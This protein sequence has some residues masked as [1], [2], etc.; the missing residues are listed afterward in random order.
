MATAKKS[1]APAARRKRGQAAPAQGLGA[2]VQVRDLFALLE[3]V[4]TLLG[5]VVGENIEVV[6]HD[7]SAPG[8]SVRAIAN[9][10]VSGRNLGDP[11]LS[12]PREDA[13]FSELYRDVAGTGTISWSIV[14]AYQ[15]TNAAGRQLRSATLLFRDGVGL[16]VAALC[17]NADMTV[18]EMAHGWL[19]QMLHRKPKP[20]RSQ[21]PAAG[22]GLEAMMQEIIDD[23][24]QRFMKPPALMNKEEK[25]YAVEAMMH[26]GLFL[27][28]NSVEQVAA[29]L[30]V[31]R[32]TIYNYIEQIKQ[33]K[34]ASRQ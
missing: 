24:V 8:S 29:A 16:P 26:R 15:T 14:D 6:L 32:F 30:G 13:G 28:R 18:F 22:V 11:I 27:I 21:A 9:G 12:G 25:M 17:L 2:G 4:V 34:A 19:E 10:H 33:K 23:A 3:P 31:S 5:G 7:L 20:P 1:A